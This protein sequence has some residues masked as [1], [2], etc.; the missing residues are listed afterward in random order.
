MTEKPYLFGYDI[1]EPRRLARALR[2]VRGVA[3]GGQKSFYECWLEPPER[4]RRF[5]A[6]A[7]LIDPAADRIVAIELDPAALAIALGRA[8]PLAN[9][10]VIL[11]G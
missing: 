9:P 7:E 11:I 1:H 4:D 8:T 2:L 10:E 6:L 5:Q 3:N